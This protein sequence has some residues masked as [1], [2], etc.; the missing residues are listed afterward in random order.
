MSND[1][2]DMPAWAQDAFQRLRG[3][4]KASGLSPFLTKASSGDPAAMHAL[5]QIYHKG[6]LV[7]R[8]GKTAREWL[9]KAVNL[10]YGPALYSMSKLYAGADGVESNVPRALELLEKAGAYGYAP[11]YIG[12]GLIYEQGELEL[13]ADPTRAAAYYAKACDVGSAR[14]RFFLGRLY[15]AGRGVPRDTRRGFELFEDSARAGD[16]EGLSALAELYETG[17]Q[18]HEEDPK[19]AFEL[20]RKAARLG[21]ERSREAIRR[22]PRIVPLGQIACSPDAARLHD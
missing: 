18:G 9:N 16:V 5:F 2:D 1:D 17:H 6:I 19:K 4:D 12:L 10:D 8:S 14:G 11:A 7:E 20:F 15:I 13:V 22:F 3:G 21:H